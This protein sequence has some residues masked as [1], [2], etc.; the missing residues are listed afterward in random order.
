MPCLS[1]SML[2]DV[3]VGSLVHRCRGS[4]AEEI[5][6]GAPVLLGRIGAAASAASIERFC[7]RCL[8]CC[9]R[10]EQMRQRFTGA[11]ECAETTS[12]ATRHGKRGGRAASKVIAFG[13]VNRK[14]I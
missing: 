9:A 10:E 8:A 6:V 13:K 12:G 11:L 7:R 5:H 2:L 4:A 1:V 14:V 3:G